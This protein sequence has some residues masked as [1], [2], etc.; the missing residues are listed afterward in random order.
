MRGI[1]AYYL[2]KRKELWRN[3]YRNLNMAKKAFGI[4]RW[5]D[6]VITVMQVRYLANSINFDNKIEIPEV[7]FSIGGTK[8]I[9]TLHQIY[10][11]QP[12]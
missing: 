2:L 3:S 7:N 4:K 6:M 10:Y 8:I 11:T 5:E 12:N 1:T 9:D